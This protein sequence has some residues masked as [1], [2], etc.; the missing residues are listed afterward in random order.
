MMKFAPFLCLAI[1]A[2]IGCSTLPPVEPSGVPERFYRA[3]DSLKSQEDGTGFERPIQEEWKEP[4]VLSVGLSGCLE[5]AQENNF[6][7][8]LEELDSEL[9]QARAIQAGAS[10]DTRIEAGL[11][12]EREETLI[13]SRFANDDRDENKTTRQ[14]ADVSLIQPF[15]TGTT[16]T[17]RH[18]LRRI[19]TN[20]PFNTFE[21]ASGISLAVEQ[22]LLD[23]FGFASGSADRLIAEGEMQASHFDLRAR[24]Q[25]VNFSVANAYW[26][27]V[28]AWEDLRVLQ[29][30]RGVDQARVD[31]ETRREAEGLATR[32]DVLRAESTLATRERE[33]IKAEYETYKRSD[34][35][36]KAI[37]PDS[38][39]G[40]Q[41]IRGYRLEIRPR[42]AFTEEAPE[43]T[44]IDV[45]GEVRRALVQR[46]ELKAAI[47]RLENTGLRVKQREQDVLPDLNLQLSGELGGNGDDYGRALDSILDNDNSTL[48]AGLTFI[49]P[50]QNSAD[51]AAQRIA[52]VEQERAVLNAREVE[53]DIIIEVVD[54][55]R[56][57]E[58]GVKGVSAAKKARDLSQRE[59]E[60]EVNRQDNGLGT[61]F[62]VDQAESDF[63]AAERDLIAARVVHE[64]AKLALARATATMA[65]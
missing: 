5:L 31:R 26:D 15:E 12:V 65:E 8:L 11:S 63:V 49:I 19:T 60:A 46:D 7:L 53:I 32:L 18:S 25:T 34:A 27:L 52:E 13:D 40:Y 55:I 9:A 62:E 54:A 22:R 42:E 10:T 35:L 56:Q 37:S 24:R 38:L 59:Y 16:V 47:K 28:L 33:I 6:D 3:L 17:L 21:W 29:R 2:L 30:Q 50:L 20:N 48:F 51:R 58:S 36:L 39:H 44:P 57:I 1:A 61:S 14:N 64:L 45:V 23:G 41:R 4:V 43:W